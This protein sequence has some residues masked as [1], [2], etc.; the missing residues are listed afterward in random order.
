MV[1]K[2]TVTKGQ[3]STEK[4]LLECMIRK[5]GMILELLATNHPF[6]LLS[7]APPIEPSLLVFLK[8]FFSLFF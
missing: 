4:I 1:K 2:G 8:S 3:N 5:K 6:L 7:P